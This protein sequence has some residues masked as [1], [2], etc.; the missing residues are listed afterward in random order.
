[1]YFN[2]NNEWINEYELVDALLT[3]HSRKKN[4][5]AHPECTQSDIIILQ[6]SMKR[7]C[8]SKQW[9]PAQGVK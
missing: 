8:P 7:S 3:V 4:V 2:M 9:Q 1:M 5:I 6:G